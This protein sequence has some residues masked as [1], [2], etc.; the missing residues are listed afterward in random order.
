MILGACVLQALIIGA[1]FLL[2]R[3]GERRA[4]V[5]YGLLLITFGLTLLHNIF[6]MTGFYDNFPSL[7]FLPIYFTLAFPPLLFYYVKLNLY[8]AY[9]FYRT[10]VKHFVLP[11]CQFIFF[12]VLF[13]APASYKSQID[14]S[15]YNPLY[16]AFEQALYLGTFFSYMYFAYRYI[17]QKQKQVRNRIE[18]K[19][20]LYLKKLVE[21]LFILFCVHAV[22]F[23]VWDFFSY[24]FL[25]INLR[26]VKPY[27]GFGALSFAALG[28][29][30]GVYGVQVLLW[31][32]R[33]FRV[34]RQ[35]QKSVSQEENPGR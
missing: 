23:V 4:N 18:A 30:M 26:T 11:V 8:P 9:K 20:T 13:F 3:T 2:M 19:K 15:F 6:F 29:W 5:F 34:E 17:R 14:R 27:A 35:K 1:M 22:F 28:L 7:R 33:L 16:G 10:D 31:G 21:I 32:R 25:N 24:E 12:V